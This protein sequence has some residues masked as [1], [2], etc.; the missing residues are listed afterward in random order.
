MVFNSKKKKKK[1]TVVAKKTYVMVSI[2]FLLENL[3]IIMHIYR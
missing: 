1:N 3:R 2:P